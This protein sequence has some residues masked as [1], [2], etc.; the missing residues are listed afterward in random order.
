ML[1]PSLISDAI[2]FTLSSNCHILPNV[3]GW[4]H[5]LYI[6]GKFNGNYNISHHNEEMKL[7]SALAANVIAGNCRLRTRQ[8]QRMINDPRLILDF[9]NGQY[10]RCYVK[11]NVEGWSNQLYING[12][13]SGNYHKVTEERK[14]RSRLVGEILNGTCRFDPL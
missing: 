9:A 3:D 12:K 8:E 7:R 6:N 14:L 2:D 10:D 5:Q 4:A 11:L 1:D 13:F